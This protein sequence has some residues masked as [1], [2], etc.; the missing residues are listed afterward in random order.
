MIS[1]ISKKVEVKN[2]VS[3]LVASLQ[4]CCKVDTIAEL[5]SVLKK[6]GEYS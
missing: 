5:H 3:F 2:D 6:I 4:V 1:I